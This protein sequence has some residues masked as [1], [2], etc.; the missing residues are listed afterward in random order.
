MPTNPAIVQSGKMN[1]RIALQTPID[2]PDGQRGVTQTWATLPGC[3]RVP[4]K[5]MYSPAPRK[6]DES[7]VAQQVYPS[8]FVVFE[9]RYRPNLNINDIQRVVY[10]DRIFN[11]RSTGVPDERRTKILLQCE[12]TQA[13]GST[14]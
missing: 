1:R 14:H 4:A 13:A 11:I 9:I 6:G 5:M 7:W 12:E 10:G 2:T 8:A 3:S